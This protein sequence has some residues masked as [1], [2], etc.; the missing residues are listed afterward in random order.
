MHDPSNIYN[1]RRVDARVTTSGQPTEEQL[2]ELKQLGVTHIINLG[3]HDHERALADEATS[4]R[5]LGMVYTHIPVEM[6][7]PTEMDFNRFCTAMSQIGDAPVHVHC[8]ANFRV[9]AF[10]YK[11]QRDVLGLEEAQARQTMDTVWR[12]GGV[13]AKFIGDEASVNLDHRPPLKAE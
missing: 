6:T 3:M 12:P 10:L 13:W 4:V 5:R 1:W 8:I 9:T 2:A 11:Y 7:N